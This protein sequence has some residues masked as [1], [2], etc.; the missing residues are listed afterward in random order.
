MPMKTM[1]VMR[2]ASSRS[3]FEREE[4]FSRAG[5]GDGPCR[6]EGRVRDGS[7]RGGTDGSSTLDSGRHAPSPSFARDRGDGWTA[8]LIATFSANTCSTICA[9]VRFPFTPFIPL[10]QNLQPTGQPTWE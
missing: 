10:A 2:E 7:S 8:P 6:S 1:L 3:K 5:D 4:L 9:P